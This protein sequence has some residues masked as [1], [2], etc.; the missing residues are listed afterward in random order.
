MKLA[1][2]LI[3]KIV[4]FNGPKSAEQILLLLKT[5][6]RS[7]MNFEFTEAEAKE[8]LKKMVNVVVCI[9]RKSDCCIMGRCTATWAGDDG[10]G[11]IDTHR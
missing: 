10:D 11:C 7:E 3:Q 8:I 6:Y 5:V 9:Y 2:D 1:E 4:H